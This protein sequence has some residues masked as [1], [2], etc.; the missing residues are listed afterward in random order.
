MG[1]KHNHYPSS[2]YNT[3]NEDEDEE[4]EID[5]EEDILSDM[6]IQDGD[7]EEESIEEINLVE[8]LNAHAEKIRNEFKN[9][10]AKK[11]GNPGNWLESLTLTHPR[12]IDEELNID[13]D[14][15]R[16]LAFYNITTQNV[17]QGLLKLKDVIC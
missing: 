8:E 10:L 2:R 4:L 9:L 11:G 16:E 3:Q 12:P 5:D 1:K 13:D 6:E 15:K 14:I 17:M 7:Q